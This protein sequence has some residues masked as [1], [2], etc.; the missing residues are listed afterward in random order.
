MKIAALSCDNVE[1]HK[2]W[3][4]DIKSHANQTA[5]TGFPYPI[6]ADES[7]DLATKLNMIDPDE[8]DADGVPLTARAVF[9]IDSKKRMRLSL[10][11][12]ATVGRNFK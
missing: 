2:N 9:I 6:I 12:P 7:R 5:C 8:K 4:E 3:I 10:L 11:Y 1:S